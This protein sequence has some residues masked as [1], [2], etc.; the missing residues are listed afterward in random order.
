MAK[1]F[2]RTFS[3]L[4]PLFRIYF[5]QS[6]GTSK[7]IGQASNFIKFYPVIP[8]IEYIQTFLFTTSGELSEEQA[9]R[10]WTECQPRCMSKYLMM[11][12]N[13]TLV[14]C[15]KCLGVGLPISGNLGSPNVCRTP[16]IR[17]SRESKCLVLNLPHFPIYLQSK[18][19]PGTKTSTLVCWAENCNLLKWNTRVYQAQDFLLDESFVASDYRP[20]TIDTSE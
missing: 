8:G 15:I 16:N 2:R 18:I 12:I 9:E 13:M 19:T 10:K 20:R 14:F 1:F 7:S 17:K 6:I 3:A 4:Y 11:M 5:L